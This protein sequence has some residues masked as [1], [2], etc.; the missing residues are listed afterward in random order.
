L[1]YPLFSFHSSLELC[2]SVLSYL[3]CLSY[4]C[5]PY[6]F[7][8]FGVFLLGVAFFLSKVTNLLT[9]CLL[10]VSHTLKAL[11][12]PESSGLISC[13][14]HPWASSLQGLSSLLEPFILSDAFSLLCFVNLSS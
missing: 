1:D 12:H 14:F 9:L 6:G 4:D 10:S 13:R 8:P 7:L 5:L 11:L 2:S 3:S